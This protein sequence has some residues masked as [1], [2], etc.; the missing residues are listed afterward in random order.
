MCIHEVGVH[1]AIFEC[2]EGVANA[3]GDIDCPIGSQLTMEGPTI[4]PASLPEVHPG[5]ED[6]ASTDADELVP[7]FRVNAARNAP[8]SVKGDVVLDTA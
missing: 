3:S 8:L 5:P 4:G 6:L 1:G 7:W 2:L